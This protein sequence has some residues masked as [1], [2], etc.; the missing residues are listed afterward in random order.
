MKLFTSAATLLSALL[1]VTACSSNKQPVSN[2]P[3]VESKGPIWGDGAEK[4]QDY[5]DVT[6]LSPTQPNALGI[7]YYSAQPPKGDV[8]ETPAFA[9]GRISFVIYDR[10]GKKIP[11]VQ[12]AGN[13]YIQG[14]TG[15]R[16]TIYFENVSNSGYEVLVTADGV[17]SITGREGKYD[18]AGYIL[19]PGSSM[20]IRGFR[21]S[22]NDHK[23]FVFNEKESP[24]IAGSN[25]GS[26]AN[27]GVIGF[28]IF[29]LQTPKINPDV[30]P[31]AFP[32]QTNMFRLD[33]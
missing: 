17:D 28:A 15:Q 7:I 12:S 23:P 8:V 31:K 14:V 20:T 24:Y 29:E 32:G 9:Q 27:I 3:E 30:K 22:R 6:R 33:K 21:E 5:L 2:L 25:Q 19:F 10:Y 1:L 13:Y 4:K 11:V 26:T 18:D 16:Y